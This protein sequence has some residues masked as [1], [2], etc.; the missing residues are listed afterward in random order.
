LLCTSDVD[1]HFLFHKQSCTVQPIVPVSVSHGRHTPQRP[2]IV[3]PIS[4]KAHLLLTSGRLETTF[5][6]FIS[7]RPSGEL[8]CS[9]LHTA[10]VWLVLSIV[11]SIL[12][13]ITFVKS[14]SSTFWLKVTVRMTERTVAW[15]AVVLKLF[16]AR[17]KIKFQPNACNPWKP[18]KIKCFSKH[19]C[20]NKKLGYFYLQ[21]AS[22]YHR[23]S[24][25]TD[26]TNS[27]V[28]LFSACHAVLVLDM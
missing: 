18:W 22:K 12:H 17:P 15:I 3:L 9:F 13:L 5:A 28:L 25:N 16:W 10:L 4:Q 19:F 27:D 21:S 20:N 1:L 24:G 8:Q 14:S 6:L 7:F 23:F 26:I 11:A 2:L